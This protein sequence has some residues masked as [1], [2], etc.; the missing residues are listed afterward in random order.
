MPATRAAN[1]NQHPGEVDLKR[2]HRNQTE[3]NAGLETKAAKEKKSKVDQKNKEAR[4]A[5]LEDNISMTDAQTGAMAD[6]SKPPKK[7]RSLRQR[8][9]VPASVDEVTR[10]KEPVPDGEEAEV[11]TEIETTSSESEVE[12]LAKKVKKGDS[13]ARTAI[14]AARKTAPEPGAD[15]QE[16]AK[17][18]S[19]QPAKKK[20]TKTKAT[21][22]EDKMGLVKTWGKSESDWGSIPAPTSHSTSKSDV[23]GASSASG[24][25]SK[26][27][28]KLAANAASPPSTPPLKPKAARAGK[29]VTK[30]KTPLKVEKKGIVS[31]DESVERDAAMSSPEKKGKRLTSDGMVTVTSNRS[32]PEDLGAQ[33][34]TDT[35]IESDDSKTSSASAKDGKDSEETYKV[36]PELHY[37]FRKRFMPTIIALVGRLDNPW[38]FVE[39]GA[40]EVDL[41]V[42]YLQMLWLEVFES[43]PSLR[44]RGY[45]KLDPESAYNNEVRAQ[46]AQDMLKDLWFLFEKAHKLP[47]RGL[48]RSVFIIR[49]FGHFLSACQGVIPYPSHNITSLNILP[50]G[51]LAIAAAAVERAVWLWAEK[52]VTI[53]GSGQIDYPKRPF[54]PKAAK[55]SKYHH[56]F[57]DLRWGGATRE[58][59]VSAKN[60]SAPKVMKIVDMARPSCIMIS[61]DEDATVGR[62]SLVDGDSDS[63]RE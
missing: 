56:H 16:I 1:K 21:S 34:T 11:P 23:Q 35:K 53:S 46:E 54:N 9:R 61:D 37:L 30:P 3:I 41:A 20:S 62:A 5:K 40:R 27:K 51:A 50:V 17:V 18:S 19:K 10:T 22:V 52:R 28:A 32:E 12:P 13:G 26:S 47:Y 36:P 38:S 42:E 8:S 44:S 48:F 63:E 58:Y 60:L 6:I 49:T 24:D 14:A 15:Q 33:S 2:K 45:A 4:I 39:C 59:V 7:D 29:K 55:E 43:T 31:D 25:T 57:S